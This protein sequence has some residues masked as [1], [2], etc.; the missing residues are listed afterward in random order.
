MPSIVC[1]I[2]VAGRAPAVVAAN[3]TQPRAPSGRGRTAADSARAVWHIPVAGPGPSWPGTSHR[4]YR[5][6]S[7]HTRPLTEGVVMLPELVTAA[8]VVGSAG[9]VYISAAAKVVKQYE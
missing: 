9:L 4:A 8:V 3:P 2:V 6:R 5:Y 1:G 7:R